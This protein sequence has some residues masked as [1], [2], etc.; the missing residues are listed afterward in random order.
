V[1]Y[2]DLYNIIDDSH[3][4][5]S[6]NEDPAEYPSLKPVELS[7]PVGVSDV[8]NFFVDFI[9]NNLLGLISN[10]HLVIADQQKEGVFHPD[11]L[12]LAEMASTAVDF[13]KTGYKVYY[14]LSYVWPFLAPNN[15]MEM[16]S[17]IGQP[18]GLSTRQLG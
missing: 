8:A 15:H 17:C 1:C 18:K 14:F 10:R 5:L 4:S 7:R 16:T 6:K 2:T 11:C 9:E 12:K 13:P 3:F